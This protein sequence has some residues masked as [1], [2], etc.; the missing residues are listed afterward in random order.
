MANTPPPADDLQHQEIIEAYQKQGRWILPTFLLVV[1]AVAVGA[2]YARP[3][4][5]WLKERRGEVLA[6]EATTAM[7]AGDLETAMLRIRTAVQIAPKSIDVAR[8]TAEVCDLYGVPEALGYWQTVVADPTANDR[9]R[10]RFVAAALRAGRDDLAEPELGRLYLKDERDLETIRLGILLLRQR[11]ELDSAIFAARR[12]VEL[13]PTNPAPRLALASL[14]VDHSSTTFRSEGRQRLWELATNPGPS[15][16]EAL[17]NL[18]H[19]RTLVPEEKSRI[20]ALLSGVQELSVESHLELLNLRIEID[21]G[22]RSRWAD[23]VA[24]RVARGTNVAEITLQLAWLHQ[25]QSSESLLKVMP[26]ERARPQP[27][28]LFWHLSALGTVGK[29]DTLTQ[30][31]DDPTLTLAP[32][33]KFGLLAA[34]AHAQGNLEASR[35][36][37]DS[38]MGAAHGQFE[39]L[40]RLARLAEEMGDHDMAMRGWSE[41]LELPSLARFAAQQILRLSQKGDRSD[42]VVLAARRLLNLSPDDLLAL[43]ELAYVLLL[44]G[45]RDAAVERQLSEAIQ[46]PDSPPGLRVTYAL[47]LLQDNRAAEALDQLEAHGLDWEKAPARWRFIHA[48]VLAANQQ[49]ESA[50]RILGGIDQ[51]RLKAAERNLASNWF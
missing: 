18:S 32:H 50:K 6:R 2:L 9:D 33:R 30:L 36:H 37:L 42:F 26:L 25:H 29:W 34:A 44:E 28:W 46:R 38:A 51:A 49:R 22:S 48:V 40:R 47:L 3:A 35:N 24:D 15:Q 10:Q 41:L 5:R 23:E 45:R 19:D 14:L 16:V 31:L 43:N 13:H 4:Y 21:P 20:A 7:R 27:N 12:G 8:V 11:G 17:V 1:V 39:E